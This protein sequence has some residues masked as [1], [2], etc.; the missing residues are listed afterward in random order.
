MNTKMIIPEGFKLNAK[1]HF[2]PEAQ[3]KEIDKLRDEVVLKLVTGA[4]K[5]Q[6]EMQVYKQHCFAELLGF[7]QLSVAEYDIK[8][9]GNKGNVTLLSFDG[10]Y[11]IVRQ[12]QD[13]LR[14]DERLQAAKEL[15]DQCISEWAADSNDN[16]KVLI[17][18]AFQVDKEG[19]ISTGRVLGLRR[20]N[21]QDEK[22]LKAMQ[23]I[24]DSIVIT[25]SKNYVRFYQRDA[26]GKYQAISL[27]FANI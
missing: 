9:G 3:V 16:I 21:I 15:I 24:S 22:W 11:K 23:A 7:M 2:V 1:G 12:I 8:L 5:L 10:E 19:K 18:D 13:S 4:K 14:F 25:D 26:D 17:Q 6:A 20:L 27:D